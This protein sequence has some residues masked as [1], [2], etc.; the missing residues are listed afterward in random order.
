PAVALERSDA[1]VLPRSTPRTHSR[2]NPL[3][4]PL[5][6]N[7]KLNGAGSVK[8]TRH[9]EFSLEDSSLDYEV[10]DALGIFPQNCPGLVDDIVRALGCKGEEFVPGKDG[11]PVP[12]REA[13][14]R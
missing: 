2:T 10:G 3:P 12:L 4:A 13:L 8:D 14:L 6:T 7:R 9:F 1:P 5:I 11:Q